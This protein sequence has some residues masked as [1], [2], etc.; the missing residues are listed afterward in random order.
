M[1]ITVLKTLEA[2]EAPHSSCLLLSLL[3]MPMLANARRT[4][5]TAFALP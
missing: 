4:S 1:H 2:F 3:T 5:A